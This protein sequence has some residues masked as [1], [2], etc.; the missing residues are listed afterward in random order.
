MASLAFK[1]DSSSL[2]FFCT[3][4]RDSKTTPEF[5]RQYPRFL[6]PASSIEVHC[7]QAKKKVD[8]GILRLF[9]WSLPPSSTTKKRKDVGALTVFFLAVA[10]VETCVT[11]R[12]R[13]CMK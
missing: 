13:R 5:R 10:S 12:H 11:A 7:L 2:E 9:L 8:G 4:G 1:V 6:P 3:L